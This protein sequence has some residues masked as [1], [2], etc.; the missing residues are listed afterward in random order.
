MLLPFRE[1]I[2]CWLYLPEGWGLQVQ[3]KLELGIIDLEL[4]A[5]RP[6]GRSS[7]SHMVEA[8]TP[9]IVAHGP[10]A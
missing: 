10:G 6:L 7:P 3:S 5:Y 4:S 2:D 1:R 9:Q 8:Y